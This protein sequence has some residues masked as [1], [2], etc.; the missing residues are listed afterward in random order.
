M[1]LKKKQKR[2]SKEFKRKPHVVRAGES[3]YDVAQR[4]GIRLKNLYK[5]NHLDSNYQI[6]V[7]DRL[8]VR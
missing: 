3:M 7:G 1:Y 2:A 8:R 4:Y 5:M 6:R